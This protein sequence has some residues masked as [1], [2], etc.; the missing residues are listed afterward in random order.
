L[1]STKTRQ[2]VSFSFHRRART[3]GF[4]VLSGLLILIAFVTG[5]QAVRGLRWPWDADHFRN[6]ANGVTFK[7]GGL[8]SDPHYAGV[9]AWYSPLTSALVGVG[10][11]VTGVSVNRLAT[12]GGVF[13][14]LVTPIALCSVTARWFGRRAAVLSLLAYLF[15]MANN[16]GPWLMAS[17][18]PWMFV[19]IY[20]MGLFIAAMVFVPDA[21]NGTSG[22]GAILLGIASGVVALAHPTIAILLAAIVVVQFLG[23][24][25]HASHTVLRRLAR[26]AAAW[27]VAALIV[28]APFWMP[29]MI[30]SRWHVA[31]SVP[32]TFSSPELNR[33]HAWAFLREFLGRW[34]VLVVAVGLLIWIALRLRRRAQPTHAESKVTSGNA[35][36]RKPMRVNGTSVLVTWTV[37]SVL[38][39]LREVYRDNPLL[40]LFPLPDA[41]P[42][43]YMLAFSV[44][45]CIWFG[46]SLNAMVRIVLRRLDGR[47]GA[48]AVAIL[49][50]GISL[51][52]VPNWRKRSDLV[53]G[54]EAA[55][56]TTAQF[57]GFA[58]VNWVRAN[59]DAD[60][61]FLN[62]G[63]GLWNGVSLPGLAGRK[64]V[65]LNV[66]PFS[67]PFTSYRKRHDAAARMVRALQ[68]CQFSRFRRLARPYGE[69]RYMI[70]NAGLSVTTACPETV[71]VVYS[72]QAVSIQRIE[73][74]R[75]R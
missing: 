52:A 49:V 23:A 39:L 27:V 5:W 8:L 67:N 22:K 61:I 17:Y 43:H 13:L 63:P 36:A 74:S 35:L 48:A 42:H 44:A 45:L 10:S 32:E 19:N 47:W 33:H 37:L 75:I 38:G 25:W 16:Y 31:N 24:C 51:W 6:I 64:S 53:E 54:R 41:P 28:S 20:A 4:L 66:P 12:Q 26:N 72:D 57:D 60:D 3:T 2:R 50:L 15:V 73:L 56:L 65:N 59:T 7:D 1:T 58:V 29:I 21:V 71:P 11:L 40:G 14:N 62:V 55:R 9:P 18:S 70:T 68:A 34:P 30:Y 46:V 69:V